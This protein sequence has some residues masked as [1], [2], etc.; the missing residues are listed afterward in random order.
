MTS[1]RSRPRR[2]QRDAA[3]RTLRRRQ[4]PIDGL[5]RQPRALRWFM[6]REPQA[7]YPRALLPR[8]HGPATLWLVEREAAEDHELV[9]VL[10][11]RFDAEL[12][13]VRIPRRVRSEHGGIDPAGVHFLERVVLQVGGHLPVPRAGGVARIPEVDLRVDDQHVLSFSR[14]LASRRVAPRPRTGEAPRVA[15]RT[16]TRS[17]RRTPTPL[18]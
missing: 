9:G 6:E 8:I 12:V 10:A 2:H 17:S 16:Q 7:E 18:V 15:D 4:E 14:P 1:S 11:G 5:F 3:P 13:R